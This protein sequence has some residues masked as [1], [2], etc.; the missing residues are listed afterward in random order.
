MNKV[1]K[2]SKNLSLRKA[3]IRSTVG[4]TSERPRLT[5]K[6]T[7]LHVSA[8]IIDDTTGNTLVSASTYKSKDAKASKT[9]LATTVGTQIAKNAKKAKVTKV[10]LDRNG[11]Q[12]HG[13]VKAFA[14]AARTEGLEF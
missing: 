2:K 11:K 1:I 5:I 3:R 10:V 9:E 4:G 14:E 7:N 6:I 12:Y 8:Q 13:I